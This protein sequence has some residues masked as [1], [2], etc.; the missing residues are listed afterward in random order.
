MASSTKDDYIRS[1]LSQVDNYR[2]RKRLKQ[3][4]EAHFDD[5]LEQFSVDSQDAIDK[6]KAELG[7][8]EEIAQQANN[9]HPSI[10]KFFKTNFNQGLIG[11]LILTMGIMSVGMLMMVQRLNKTEAALTQLN[12]EIISLNNQV[13]TV[14]DLKTR[15]DE[16]TQEMTSAQALMFELTGSA[17]G[18]HGSQ[19]VS[20]M[21]NPPYVTSLGIDISVIEPT[22]IPI[23]I[24]ILGAMPSSIVV[25]QDYGVLT[26]SIKNGTQMKEFMRFELM[27]ASQLRGLRS[28]NASGIILT[29]LDLD[30]NNGF[31]IVKTLATPVDLSGLT[32]TQHQIIE[33]FL[34]SIQAVYAFHS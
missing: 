13:K 29:D 22:D 16:M 21:F 28:S 7:S 25:L 24:S 4:L 26:L 17:F 11:F 5:A 8:P 32:D 27:S 2:I 30:L 33:D 18:S 19:T 23:R 3:E 12:Y 6:V 9:G 15:L 10:L 1:V 20:V 14:D 34:A 31:Y